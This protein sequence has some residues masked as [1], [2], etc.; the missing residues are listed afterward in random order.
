MTEGRPGSINKLGVGVLVGGGAY[1]EFGWEKGE[2]T[3]VF[4]KNLMLS[5]T[6]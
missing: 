6:H 2:P 4:S 3:H 1:R 5:V